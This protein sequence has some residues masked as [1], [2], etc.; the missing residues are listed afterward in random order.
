MLCRDTACSG[1]CQADHVMSFGLLGWSAIGAGA[2]LLVLIPL[3]LRLT[4]EK[5][6]TLV[7]VTMTNA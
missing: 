3:V 4:Q 6:L 1:R 5:K 2:V 7:P